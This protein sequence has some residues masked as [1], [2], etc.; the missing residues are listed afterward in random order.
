MPDDKKKDQLKIRLAEIDAPESDQPGGKESTEYL[1]VIKHVE[2]SICDRA[3]PFASK[4]NTFL[5][6]SN[7]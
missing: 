7:R 1:K 3:M 2:S 4:P 5:P 6:N